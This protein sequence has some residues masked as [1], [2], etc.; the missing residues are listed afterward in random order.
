MNPESGLDGVPTVE[1]ARAVILAVALRQSPDAMLA[2]LR[3]ALVQLAEIGP[4][5]SGEVWQAYSE[6]LAIARPADLSTWARVIP[7]STS[8]QSSS[9]GQARGP[10][11]IAP[12]SM[13]DIEGSAHADD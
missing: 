1:H 3:E 13:V 9:R 8:N 11:V 4:S 12:Q 7:L 6:V 2:M 5:L 10:G